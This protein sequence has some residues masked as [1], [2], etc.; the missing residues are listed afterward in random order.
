LTRRGFDV[1]EDEV[2]IQEARRGFASALDALTFAPET[3]A[4]LL[5]EA[6]GQIESV[7]RRLERAQAAAS[8]L[9][10]VLA[11]ALVE[12]GQV[13]RQVELAKPGAGHSKAR[14][15]TKAAARG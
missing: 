15:L 11:A 2:R 8:R 4:T 13:K 10:E 9:E 14:E 7:S 3:A 5:A 1:A 6:R 12:L